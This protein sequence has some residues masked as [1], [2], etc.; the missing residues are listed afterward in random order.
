MGEESYKT[1][2]S[3]YFCFFPR[4]KEISDKTNFL[5]SF[6]EILVINPR[7]ETFKIK[8]SKNRGSGR[9]VRKVFVVLAVVCVTHRLQKVYGGRVKRGVLCMLKRDICRCLWG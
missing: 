3:P 2:P 1:K 6:F 5:E 4:N 8:L 7:R 9:C